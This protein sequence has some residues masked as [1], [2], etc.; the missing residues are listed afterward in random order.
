M[1]KKNLPIFNITI[2]GEDQDESL[3][4]KKTAYTANPAILTKG[5]AFN[6]IEVKQFTFKDNVKM[7]IVAPVMIPDLPI[8]RNDED[9]EYYVTFTKEN[10]EKIYSKKMAEYSS[11]DVNY[12]MDHKDDV[13]AGKS[14]MLESWIVGNDPLKDKAY[15]EFGIEVPS[16]TVMQINQITDQKFYNELVENNM[17]GFSIEGFL[18][19]ELKEIIKNNKL[20]QTE[21]MKQEFKLADGNM[22]ILN[23]D[24][25]TEI[26]KIELEEIVDEEIKEE[27]VDEKMEEIVDEKEEVI[28]E[29]M[30]EIVE[31]EIV[32]APV[33]SYSKE[34]V[35]AKFEELYK[36]IGDLKAEE[37][38][39]DEEE[40]K[41]PVAL[42]IH[43]KFSNMVNF[44][45]K[46]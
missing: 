34:E 13:D 43:Q 30:E 16:G 20:K 7:R 27:I 19:L 42:N 1:L 32:D 5:F 38:I 15:S 12:N 41:A 17:T 9:G 37:I 23:E 24:G 2:D 3:G 18:G 31:E 22:L 40:V 25:T 33:E 45:G 6:D 21:K 46:K 36:I 29:K 10:I 28:E 4:W 8:Y 14:Y 26:I 35:D 11:K 44:L 39:E